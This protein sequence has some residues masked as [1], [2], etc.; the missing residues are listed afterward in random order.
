[1]ESDLF[2]KNA[3][4]AAVIAASKFS[5]DKLQE[6]FSQ[7]DFEKKQISK[8]GKKAN[9]VKKTVKPIE[10]WILE[11]EVESLYS[12]E[13][14]KMFSQLPESMV[15]PNLLECMVCKPLKTITISE[16]QLAR[17][18]NGKLH[19]GQMKGF[20]AIH[21]PNEGIYCF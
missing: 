7:I 21:N 12:G 3:K 11:I 2:E 16:Q 15:G 18:V 8:A 5:E 17:H 14:L 4:L 20:K 1:M 9:N 13:H 6:I 10:P 19:Q